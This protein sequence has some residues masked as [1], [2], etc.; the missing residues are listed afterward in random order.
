MTTVGPIADPPVDSGAAPPGDLT[1][2]AQANGPK[3]Q[4]PRR[5]R[6]LLFP[7]LVLLGL[8]LVLALALVSHV[9]ARRLPLPPNDPTPRLPARPDRAQWRCATPVGLPADVTITSGRTS[10]PCRR[11][12]GCTGAQ[13]PRRCFHRRTISPYITAARHRPTS[14]TRHYPALEPTPT[15]R[16]RPTRRRHPAGRSADHAGRA[17]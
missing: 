8:A 6:T 4:R 2:E 13:E 9:T 14:R 1:T 7:V 3:P 10:I 12:A 11:C 16:Q 5:V 15:R 17:A